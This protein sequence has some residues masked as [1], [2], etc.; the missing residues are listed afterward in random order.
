[1]ADTP[2]ET[3]MVDFA[4]DFATTPKLTRL[5]WATKY[6][7]SE[8]T[9]YNWLADPRIVTIIDETQ[10]QNIKIVQRSIKS[11][12]NHIVGELLKVAENPAIDECKRK[13]CLDLLRMASVENAEEKV[14]LEHSVASNVKE[15]LAK[16]TE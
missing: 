15:I 13:A 5:D 4:Y 12:V 10:Q 9:I 11:A 16:Y 7:V 2:L 14:K 8:R 1:M 3:R 6:A